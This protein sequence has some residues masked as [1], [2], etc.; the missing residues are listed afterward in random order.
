MQTPL[1]YG[2]Q[3]HLP[4]PCI[5]FLALW[6]RITLASEKSPITLATESH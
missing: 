5:L 3:D 1:P 2:G 6:Q 4:Y